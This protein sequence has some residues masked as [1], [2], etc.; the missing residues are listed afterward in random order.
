MKLGIISGFLVILSTAALAQDNSA[1]G[2]VPAAAPEPTKA[3][4]P[5]PQGTLSKDGKSWSVTLGRLT[6]EGFY[7]GYADPREVLYQAIRRNSQARMFSIGWD[8]S[9]LGNWSST[10][11]RYDR[12]LQ[13]LTV[14]INSGGMDQQT[15]STTKVYKMISQWWVKTGNY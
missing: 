7:F 15:T 12:K 4:Q 14:F 10:S 13:R 9:G 11:Y 1:S 6:D 8:E 2:R 3:S 5:V